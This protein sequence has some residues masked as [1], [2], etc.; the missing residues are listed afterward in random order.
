MTMRSWTV[1]SAYGLAGP[2]ILGILV[3]SS[4]VPALSQGGPRSEFGIWLAQVG[5]T[6][7][8]QAP[9][10]QPIWGVSCNGTLQGLDCSAVQSVQMTG[11]G[12]VA[13]ALRIT[14]DTK[15]PVLKLVVPAGIDLAAGVT[16]QFGQ[17]V[18]KRVALQVCDGSGCLAEYAI[19]DAEIAALAE[20]Q[21]I[22]VSECESSIPVG[23]SSRHRLRRGLHQDQIAS[24]M[25][26]SWANTSTAAAEASWRRNPVCC[27]APSVAALWRRQGIKFPKDNKYRTWRRNMS[28]DCGCQDFSII[29]PVN[30][31]FL[32]RSFHSRGANPG[33]SSTWLWRPSNKSSKR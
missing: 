20:G 3:F 9:K 8:A 29:E 18:A 6:Q 33:L 5:Q 11:R 4:V 1:R 10:P 2:A 17:N 21:P 30:L 15:K 7:S 28:R 24:R 31:G 16:L 26:S 19:A 14:P 23:G 22:V 12:R 13:V 32:T 27:S 25:A